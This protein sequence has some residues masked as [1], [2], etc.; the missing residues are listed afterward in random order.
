MIEQILVELA[1]YKTPVRFIRWGEPLLHPGIY[2]VLRRAKELEIPTHINTNGLML[3]PS[4][5]KT[6]IATGVDS[7]KISMQGFD[8]ASYARV[9]GV[10]FFVQLCED[11]GGLVLA[12]GDKPV[13]RIVVGTTIEQKDKV[14]N[15]KEDRKDLEQKRQLKIQ[16]GPIDELYV[17]DTLD[18]AAKREPPDVCPEVWDKLS[19][20]WDGKVSA[21]CG[22]YDNYMVVG[23]IRTGAV[24]LK[25]IWVHS[26]KLKEYRKKLAEHDYKGLTLCQRCARGI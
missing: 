20:D 17:G 6:L 7:I 25:T 12:R 22:D 16:L 1:Q 2:A 14:L 19:I 10:D 24:D 26:K 18:L 11:I 15:A 23:D 13:P 5:A 3:S 4:I 8:R 21:C 9:R